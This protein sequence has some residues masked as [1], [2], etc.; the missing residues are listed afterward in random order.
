MKLL[1]EYTAKHLSA[2][3]HYLHAYA[4]KKEQEDLHQLRVCLKKIRA[5]Q[6]FLLQSKPG[7]RKLQKSQKMLRRLF[8]TAGVIRQLELKN[9]WLQKNRFDLFIKEANMNEQLEAD[10]ADFSGE[11]HVYAHQLKECGTVFLHT[12]S[13]LKNETLEN[14]I[15][16]VKQSVFYLLNT[17]SLTDWHE[18]RKQIKQL[19]YARQWLTQ[20]QKLHLLTVTEYNYLNQLQEKIGSWH[21]LVD[22]KQWLTDKEFFLHSDV[23]IKKTFKRCWQK[24]NRQLLLKE[25]QV[26]KS[27]PAAINK[28]QRH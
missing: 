24:L 15:E 21:D 2:A 19:L 13:K 8:K 26:Q 28:K 14:Y 25:Q 12:I 20:N 4:Q 1:K 5:A 7:V 6:N 9:E 17:G 18:L 16:T 11:E 23:E 10:R 3:L 22:L 27:L